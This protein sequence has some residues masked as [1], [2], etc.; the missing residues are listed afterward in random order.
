MQEA[1]KREKAHAEAVDGKEGTSL[2]KRLRLPLMIGGGVLAAIVF[3]LMGIWIGSAKRNADKKQYEERIVAAKKQAEES[4][5]ERKILEAKLDGFSNSLK[6]R[7][8]SEESKNA[9]ITQ[10][11]AKLECFE[12]ATSQALA[13]EQASAQIASDR[14][15]GAKAKG[16]SSPKRYVRFGN[17]SCTLVAGGGNNNWK[18]CLKQG[19]P[20]VGAGKTH[21][22]AD[23]GVKTDTATSKG[24]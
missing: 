21:V 2:V 23:A 4:V 9:L 10:L 6:E 19:K 14:S 12:Q 18:D 20:V 3:L 5:A 24:H 11:Q 8:E 16:E 7:K 1:E 15:L 13:A 17:A 22:P